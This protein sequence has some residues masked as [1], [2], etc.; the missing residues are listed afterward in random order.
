MATNLGHTATKKTA[1]ATKPDTAAAKKTAGA[2]EDEEA[3]HEEDN[4]PGHRRWRG[5]TSWSSPRRGLAGRPTCLIRA[6]PAPAL[7]CSRPMSADASAAPHRRARRRGPIPRPRLAR[8]PE[9]LARVD[10]R[11]CGAVVVAYPG[12]VDSS[13]VLLRV[14]HDVLGERAHGVIGRSGLCTPRAE[15]AL[16]LGSRPPPSAPRS[17]SSP[18]VS[19][20]TREFRANPTRPLLPL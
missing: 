14:A 6:Q 4:R 19:W 15:L 5:K 3:S 7:C 18:P 8:A 11:P 1:A 2:Y 13:L 10:R 9:R 20:P 12:G 16:A 17:R